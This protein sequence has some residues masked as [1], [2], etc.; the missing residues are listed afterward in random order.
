MEKK[1]KPW[2]AGEQVSFAAR[3]IKALIG[4]YVI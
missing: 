4:S 1:R 2:L 3:M